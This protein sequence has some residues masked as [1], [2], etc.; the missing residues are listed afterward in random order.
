MMKVDVKE[1]GPKGERIAIPNCFHKY[2]RP[3]AL[4]LFV[5]GINK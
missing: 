3:L 2:L 5:V 4:K 1:M